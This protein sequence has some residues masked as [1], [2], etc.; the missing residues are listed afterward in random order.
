LRALRRL[1]FLSVVTLPLAL[2]G[3]GSEQSALAPESG[4]AREISDLWWVMMSGGW[5]VFGGTLAFLVIGWARRGKTGWPLLGDREEASVAL[6]VGFGLVVPL[7]VLSVLFVFANVHVLAATSAPKRGSTSLTVQVTGHQW[8]WEV[9]YPGTEAVT[10]N[11]LH[12]PART[13][14]LVE[15]RTADVIHSF[16]VP[17]LN[18]KI[19][20]VPG[21]TN[22]VL[23]YADRPGVYR[24]QCSEFCGLQHAH[25]AFLVRAD[26]P[27]AFHRWLDTMAA[28]RRPPRTA[29]ERQ[30][31]E[32]FRSS[33]CAGCHTIRGTDA[34]GDV[35]PDLTH[36]GS[37]T[38][39]A[40]VAIPNEPASLAE[41]I[42]DPQHVKPGAKMPAL[43]L[44]SQQVD[45]L[46]AYL[47]SLK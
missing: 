25:M 46:V 7:V 45:A 27:D 1:S 21:R 5:I 6:V 23:L 37:R 35:G 44:T 17:R 18:R 36:V 16:W 34:A 26:P 42:R 14:V 43:G 20:M 11:E 28:D 13:R 39:L 40:G 9:R 29:A 19:D 31:E 3:C 2:T 47:E 4:P 12:I 33:A 32:L 30:G 8:F 24:G 22:R 10:A 15:A 41:W 38:T